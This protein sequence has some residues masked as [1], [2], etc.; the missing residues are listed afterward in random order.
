MRLAL[1]AA[2]LLAPAAARAADIVVVAP[3]EPSGPYAEALR[4]ICDALAS[5]PPVLTPTAALPAEARVVIAL[6]RRAA[7]RTVPA[8]AVLVTALTPG[9]E[10][11][12]AP[13]S[14]PVVRV[15][16]TLSPDDFAGRLRALRP[17]T[18]R[19]ALLWTAPASGRFAAAV[20][21]AARPLGIEAFPVETS[22][23][24]DELPPLLRAMAEV[25]AVW[26]APDPELVT[27]AV[28]DEV[29]ESARARGAAFYSPAP[30]LTGRGAD[31]ALA[32]SFRAV[33]ERAGA[34]AHDAL[35]GR[36][37]QDTVYPTATFPAP[38]SALLVST[39]AATGTSS[40]AAAP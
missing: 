15:G 23:P 26:L 21:D 18:R 31:P 9:F 5:C 25:D 28:F 35:A 7:R 32:P 10:A 40:R 2:L 8:R 13:G 20:R 29:A 4:G 1:A 11:R 38:L 37:A 34:A 22:D 24:P 33:G 6:G 39:P 36:P 3:E 17:G 19:I 12:R 14:G 16:L 30:G 27:Q